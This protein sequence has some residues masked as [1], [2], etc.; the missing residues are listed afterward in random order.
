MTL[1]RVWWSCECVWLQTC[2]EGADRDRE[3]LCGG[4][5]GGA[6]GK[7]TFIFLIVALKIEFK[8]NVWGVDALSL[9]LSG[10]CRATGLKW[11]IRLLLRSCQQVFAT[12]E[13][14]SLETCLISTISTAGKATHSHTCTENFIASLTA[15]AK[16]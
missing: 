1:W 15:G 7:L 8:V 3:D 11:T 4:A 14:C 13:M 10:F 9:Y 16:W 2:D 5:A 6:P 12:R